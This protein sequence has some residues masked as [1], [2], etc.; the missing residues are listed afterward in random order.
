MS[1]QLHQQ[2]GFTLIEIIIV[3]LMGSILGAM[4][5]PVLLSTLTKS[6]DPLIQL[7][8]TLSTQQTMEN[9]LADYE[10]QKDDN[11]LII[12]DFKDGIGNVGV[13]SNAY[14]TY[15]VV[16]N[17]YISIDASDDPDSII[18]VSIKESGG[19]TYTTVFIQ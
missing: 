17:D 14:G 15:T 18:E 3:L 9:I 12:G 6:G 13:I 16:A 8:N 7:Q 11:T 19:P 5:V 10:K 2:R 1:S 4:L